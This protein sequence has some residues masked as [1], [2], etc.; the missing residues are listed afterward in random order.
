DQHTPLLP[1]ALSL[2]PDPGAPG[3]QLV[4]T[5]SLI[6]VTLALTATLAWR[7][8]GPI[9]MLAATTLYALW[10]LPF[11]GAHL[12]YD[13]AL[14]P[15]YLAAVLVALGARDR[16]VSPTHILGVALVL[17]AAVLVKQHAA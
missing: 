14:A 9:G 3:P 8:S 4:F 10:V 17:G 6:A 15:F 16:L 2:L 11:E 7:L 12:W 13:L 5:V 1:F